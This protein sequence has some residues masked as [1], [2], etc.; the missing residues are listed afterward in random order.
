MQLIEIAN[1][2]PA[3]EVAGENTEVVADTG[4]FGSLGIN[5]TL[6]TFQLINFAVVA[7]I[8]WYLI[9]KPITKKMGER[10]KLIDDSIENAK[11]IESNLAHSEQKYQEK[12]DMAKVEANRILEKA[13]AETEIVTAE[14]KEKAKKEI[15]L[16]VEQAKKNIKLDK[17][18]MVLEVKKEMA[19]LVAEALERV[20]GDKIDDKKDVKL[21]EESLAKI[22]Q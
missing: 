5:G 7:V 12:I 3:P 10:A 18:E 6:F 2:S 21:I 16:L 9:L 17:D 4:I 11:K 1:A 14:M 20:L 15:N 22:G 19:T 13:N 8:L